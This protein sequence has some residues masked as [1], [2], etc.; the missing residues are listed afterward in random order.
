M[1]I[2]CRKYVMEFLFLLKVVFIIPQRN[3]KADIVDGRQYDFSNGFIPYKKAPH[4][5]LLISLTEGKFHQVRKMVFA[6]GHRCKRLIRLSRED[7]HLDNLA[8]GEVKK[9]SE[10]DFFDLLNI[11]TP[12]QYNQQNI[13]SI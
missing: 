3:V 9:Y 13:I 7:M 1:R 5:W 8:N 2:L 10:E 11:L 6:L 4:T 12:F